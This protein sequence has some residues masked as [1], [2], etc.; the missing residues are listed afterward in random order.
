[1]PRILTSGARGGKDSYRKGTD[2]SDLFVRGDMDGDGIVNPLTD[3]IFL[4]AYGFNGGPLSP[5]LEAAD[6]NSD[7]LVSPIAD[8]IYLLIYGFANGAPPPPAFPDCGSDPD[9]DGSLGCLNPPV[10]CL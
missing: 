1:M 6:A 9:P 4:L 8:A 5:C 10:P 7:G 3:P 2:P